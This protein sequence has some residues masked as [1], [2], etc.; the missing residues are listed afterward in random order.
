MLN[1][2]TELKKSFGDTYI[3]LDVLLLALYEDKDIGLLFLG[4]TNL[5]FYC[6]HSGDVFSRNDLTKTKCEDTIKAVR[7]SRKVDSK[8]AEEHFEVVSPLFQKSLLA[9]T[10]FAQVCSEPGRVGRDGEVR[11]SNR[12]G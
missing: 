5:I 2:A 11:S 12:Q 10:G 8:G 1:K 4:Q 9:V 3:A 6:F 7:G